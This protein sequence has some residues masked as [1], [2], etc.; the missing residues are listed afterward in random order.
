M[1]K[2]ID[3]VEI[4]NQKQRSQEAPSSAIIKRAKTIAK[5]VSYNTHFKRK[6]KDWPFSIILF[7]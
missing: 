4:N 7:I 3:R 2:A 5:C 6:K 1:N